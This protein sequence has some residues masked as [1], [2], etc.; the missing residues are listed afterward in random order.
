RQ[1]N[2]TWSP[3]G[4]SIAFQQ[5]IAGNELWD[6]FTIPRDGGEAIN[7]TGTPDVREEGPRWSPD[8]NTLAVNRK[9]KDATVYDIALLDPATRNLR[10]LTHETTPNHSWQSIAWSS[11]GRTLYANRVEVSFQDSDIY[12][13]EMTTG[14]AKNLTAHQGQ[15]LYLG[16]SLSP[17]GKTLLVTSN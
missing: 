3:D 9:P 13:I 12:A 17:D 6:I 5:D 14:N 11:D 2:A 7:L 8:G 1:Y 10:L 15:V 16:S 4:K